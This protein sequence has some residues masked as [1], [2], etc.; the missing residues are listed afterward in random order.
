MRKEK[1]MLPRTSVR[2]EK[3]STETKDRIV[4]SCGKLEK[5]CNKIV[6]CEFII[7]KEKRGYRA[8]FIVSVPQHRITATG[9]GYNLY[10]AI[11]EGENKAE[12]QLKKYHGKRF[13][14]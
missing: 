12:G 4:R 9:M 8:E 11:A 13:A 6:D 7:D 1:A 3:V 14:Y 5:Y 10:K 2:H